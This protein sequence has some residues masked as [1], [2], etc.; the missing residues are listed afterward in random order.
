[1]AAADV[2]GDTPYGFSALL[3]VGWSDNLLSGYFHS[4]P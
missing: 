4:L 1:M 2:F 3:T